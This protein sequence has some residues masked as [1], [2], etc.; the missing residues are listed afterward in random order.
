MS[1]YYYE[2]K[3][4]Y[5]AA[6]A[7]VRAAGHDL[8]AFLRFGLRGVALQCGRLLAEIRAQVKKA[9]FRDVM[10]D[11]FGRLESPRKRVMARRQVELLRLLLE[12]DAIPMGEFLQ[13]AV[14]IYAGLK[15]WPKIFLRDIFHLKR[16]GAMSSQPA[17]AGRPE[18][19]ASYVIN[20]D[21][22]T[23]ITE[24]EFFERVKN[25]AKARRTGR[26]LH[27]HP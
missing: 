21:W 25:L 9:L 15:S 22:P 10:L 23:Q 24:T 6:L 4:A 3:D 1:N 20:L 17:P 27:L 8:T 14:P 26:S 7:E 18:Q 2:E 12:R 16:L 13:A 11:L 19:E 5:L